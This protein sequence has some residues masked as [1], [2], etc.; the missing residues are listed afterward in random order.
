MVLAIDAC[1]RNHLRRKPLQVAVM[2]EYSDQVSFDSLNLHILYFVKCIE[3]LFVVPGTIGVLQ[4]LEAIKII[5]GLPGVL[6]GRLL[7][8]DGSNTTF[9]N[10]TL[11]PKNKNC[12]V[13][14]EN[15]KILDLIDYE[16]FCNA[17]A[18][19]KV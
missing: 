7:L 13:C 17:K 6:S 16:Q 18:H 3:Y 11:R 19:D 10:V 14:G 8:F 2:V 15:P 4:A 1:F 5:I 9:R 12:D